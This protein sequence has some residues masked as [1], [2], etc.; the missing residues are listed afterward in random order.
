MLPCSRSERGDLF[1]LHYSLVYD[2][3]HGKSAIDRCGKTWM[4]LSARVRA[5]PMKA[6]PQPKG[7]S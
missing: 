1:S 4:P 6:S 2:I 7:T 5:R 3:M